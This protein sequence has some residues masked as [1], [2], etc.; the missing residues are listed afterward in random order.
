M[1]YAGVVEGADQWIR[2]DQVTRMTDEQAAL[3]DDDSRHA[4]RPFPFVF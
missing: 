2:P 3:S 4:C 1:L